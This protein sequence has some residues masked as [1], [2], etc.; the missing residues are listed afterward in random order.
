MQVIAP[1][2]LAK[3]QSGEIDICVAGEVKM[4]FENLAEI[5]KKGIK[6][7]MIDSGLD[8]E[9]NG[10]VEIKLQNSK[11]YDYTDSVDWVLLEAEI[12]LLRDAQKEIEKRIKEAT[13]TPVLI[14]KRLAISKKK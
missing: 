9:S 7:K 3:I 11:E 12:D 2:L 10:N 1:V 6:A 4:L 13:G 5:L 14:K 8:Y